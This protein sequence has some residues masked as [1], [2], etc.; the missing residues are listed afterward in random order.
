MEHGGVVTI[1]VAVIGLLLVA[2]AA[3]IGLCVFLFECRRRSAFRESFRL[4]LGARSYTA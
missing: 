3:A 1:V 2:A 4:L